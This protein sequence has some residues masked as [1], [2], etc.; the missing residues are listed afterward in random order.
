MSQNK[1]TDW[2]GISVCFLAGIAAAIAMTKV[3]PA[4]LDLR[5]SMNVS[6]L[7]IGWLMSTAAI[8]IFMFG[9]LAGRFT[10]QYGAR[11]ILKT[12]LGILFIAAL[13]ATFSTT[14]SML[15][16]ARCIEGFGVILVIVS[17]PTLI[18]NLSR[19][20][21]IGLSM[22][23]WALWMPTG[24][25]I[26]LTIAPSLLPFYGW[27]L[28]WISSAVA[29]AVVL[30][31]FRFL[32]DTKVSK[33]KSVE[34]NTSSN[35][36]NAILLA[37]VF[38]CF[39]A[40]FFSLLTYLPTFIHEVMQQTPQRA[41]FIT[42]IL[43]LFIIPGNLIGGYFI[44]RGLAPYKLMAYP[45]IILFVLI[46]ILFNY[47]SP[48]MSGVLLLAAYGLFTGMIP[49]AIFAQAPRLAATPSETGSILGVAVSGQGL[50]VLCGPPTVGYLAST[51]YGWGI[52]IV[53]M[54]SMFTL[55]AFLSSKL[56]RPVK[57]D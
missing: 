14:P 29:C 41:S 5:Q 9:V 17:A 8:A 34:S 18:S 47:A 7:Q 37:L 25:L 22:G 36:S 50:G 55:L 27:R 49:T 28:L 38:T 30:V 56:P 32:P 26:V 1:T 51:Q 44:H 10:K 52:V 39:S 45:S 43:P 6:L 35:T 3:S 2:R 12:G 19:D 23:I 46:F 16:A 48:N 40:S 13:L 4:A 42:S 21:D 20:S 31:L 33:P 24:G 15:I 11:K 57:L 54:M 53:F